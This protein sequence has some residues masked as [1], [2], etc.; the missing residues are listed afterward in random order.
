MA[1][2]KKP[3]KMMKK[4][5]GQVKEVFQGEPGKIFNYKQVSARLNIKDA[6][7]QGRQVHI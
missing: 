3:A 4:L 6:T 2:K 5:A 7:V 1:K